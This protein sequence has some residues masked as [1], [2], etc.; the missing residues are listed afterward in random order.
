MALISLHDRLLTLLSV[1]IA[2]LASFTALDLAGRLRASTGRA[3]WVWLV[4]ASLALGGGIWAMHFVAMLAFSMPGMKTSY[5]LGL[6]ILSLAIAIAFTGAGFVVMSRGAATFLR[7]VS[8]GLLVGAGVLTMHY[9]GMAAMRMDASVS[10]ERTWVGISALIAVGAAMAAIWLASRDR[11]TMHRFAAAIAMGIAISGMHFAGMRAATFKASP[12]FE[13]SGSDASIG[14]A[15]LGVGVGAVTMLVLLIALGAARLDLLF[16]GISRREARIAMRLRIA[17]A[18][19]SDQCSDAFE[20]ITA[21]LGEHFRVSRVCLVRVDADNCHIKDDVCWSADAISPSPGGHSTV[22]FDHG[23]LAKLRHGST[24]F[25][26]DVALPASDEL[27]PRLEV[28]REE[29]ARAFLAVPILSSGELRAVVYLA[30][31]DPRSWHRQD[32]QFVEEIAERIRLVVER[33]GVED[34]LRELNAN[35]EAHIEER[36]GELRRAEE[37]RR[38]ADALHRA[39]FENTPDPLFIVGVEEDG[40]FV[41]EQINPAHEAGVG[42]HLQEVRGKRI[43]EIMSPELS[44]KVTNAY[45][46]VVTTGSIYSYREVFDLASEPQHWD[47]TLVPLLD[48]DGRIAR[49]IGSSRNVTSQV[50]AEEALRQSQKMEAMGQ[51]TGGVAHDFNNLLT[52]ILGVLDMLHC[53][54]IGTERDRRLIDGAMQSA[55]RAKTLVQRLLSFARRQ[56]LQPV[57]VDVS[58]LVNGMIDLVTSTIGPQVQLT[59]TV[60]DGLAPATADHNQ[61]EM[62]LLNLSVNA[63]DAMPHGGAL[64]ISVAEVDFVAGRSTGPRS[65][66]Y[67]CLTVADTGVGMDGDTIARAIEPFFSTKGVGQGTGL[68]LSMVHGLAAQLGGALTIESEPGV[69]TEVTLWLPRSDA[70]V[71]GERL[72]SAGKAPKPGMG[73]VLLVDDEDLVRDTTGEMLIDLGYEVVFA[74]CAADALVQLDQGLAPDV[75]ITDHLMPGMTG[76]ELAREV[77]KRLPSTR[78]LI[79][80]GYADA[81][82]IDPGLAR[83]AKPFRQAD[84]AAML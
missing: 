30:D 12:Q 69:G 73:S 56:P 66:R 49:I 17:D 18:L 37:A 20:Q 23:V 11:Q 79:V 64:R 72:A 50:I 75:L 44:A 63:R 67:L 78:V 65:G 28:R 1:T 41:V 38:E 19:R 14:Q 22:S 2:I 9:I 39:Y 16:Q 62:A 52:P 43:D 29:R 24:V 45:R 7:I 26:D 84:L 33:A 81:D 53:K 55:E 68:G 34:Q 31:R 32:V 35:L 77:R 40:G 21:M 54:G 57:P 58:A 76:T 82:D 5:D 42:F 15:Y 70:A 61:L 6:T 60:P 36:T 10:Y 74:S 48:E 59:V 3:G 25:V 71:I 83:L 13:L 47:T 80:S 8:A 27:S 46:Q 4:A 51:L